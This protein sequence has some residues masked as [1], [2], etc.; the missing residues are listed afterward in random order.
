MANR[1]ICFVTG[2]RAEFGLMQRTL[3]AIADHSKLDLQIIATGMHLDRSRGKSVDQIAEAGF[4]VDAVVPW[5]GSPAVATGR[6][7]SGIAKQID[8]LQSDVVLVVGDRVEAFAAASAAHLSGK[9][10]AHVHGGDRAQGQVDDALR[11]AITKLSHIHFAATDDSAQRLIQLGEDRWRVQRVGA[12]GIDGIC[13]DASQQAFDQRDV[14][15][16]ILLVLHPTDS[17]TNREYGRAD[18]VYRC[19]SKFT[20]L[21]LVIIYPNNDPGSD[22]IVRR[23]AEICNP[24]ASSFRNVR[25]GEFLAA[26]RDAAVLVGNSSAGIIEAAS[27]GTPVVNVGDR[28]AGRLCSDNVLH[29]PFSSRAVAAAVSRQLQLPAS[30]RRR[31]KNIYGGART[32][33][34]IAKVLSTVPLDSRLMSKLIAY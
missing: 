10:V 5:R 1:R 9:P 13:E 14:G 29:V 3:R 11:H 21:P 15:S 26:L 8:R 2:T 28:Q 32:A 7:M 22:G 27:F 16:F 4:S 25:R 12:P 18:L 23:W 30:V 24:K 34:K 20:S 6:A 31:F 19:L 33:E 17:D